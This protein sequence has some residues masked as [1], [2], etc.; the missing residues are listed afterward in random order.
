MKKSNP[1]INIAAVQTALK[2]Y[3]DSIGKDTLPRHY[4][5]E[6]SLIHF[7][8]VGNCK[9]PCDLKSLPRE[10]MHIVRRVICLNIRLIKLH[11]S[12]KD[13]KQACRELVLKYEAKLLK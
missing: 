12:Y 11:V 6:V 2:N 10:K 3:R 7:A 4:I 8:V 9:P 5:N 13:R 1:T